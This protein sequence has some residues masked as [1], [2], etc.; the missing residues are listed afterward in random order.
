MIPFYIIFNL[1]Y[2]RANLLFIALI[3]FFASPLYSQIHCGLVEIEPNTSIN[4]LLTFDSFQRY[5]GGYTINSVARIRVKVENKST[6]DPLCS[7]SLRMIVE[8]NSVSGTPANEWEELYLYGLGNSSNPTIDALEIRV[9]NECNTSP[10]DGVFT[11]FNNDQDIIDIIAPLL[12]VTPAGSCTANVNGPGNY[13]TNYNEFNFNIDIKV[14]P[15]FA[16]NPGLFE[17]NVKFVL[18][19]NP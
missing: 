3:I 2:L 9:R 5:Q 13:Q 11:N 7:W 15:N 19:E 6:P 10:I 14:K 16:F 18:E 8:N 4:S 1:K 17:L 12:A